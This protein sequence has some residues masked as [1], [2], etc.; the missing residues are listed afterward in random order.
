MTTRVTLHSLTY[1]ARFSHFPLSYLPWPFLSRCHGRGCR[2]LSPAT[3][4]SP[5]RRLISHHFYGLAPQRSIASPHSLISHNGCLTRA[6][7]PPSTSAIPSL[8]DTGHMR[9][10]HCFSLSYYRYFFPFFSSIF[11]WKP[12]LYSP[13]N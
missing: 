12:S 13:H 3:M 7:A 8:A 5:R 10:S 2:L 6:T 1:L 9:S 11:L 4:A